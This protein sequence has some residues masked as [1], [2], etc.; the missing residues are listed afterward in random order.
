MAW[1]QHCLYHLADDGRAVIVLANGVL[2][3]GGRSGRIRQRIVKAGLLDAVIALPPGLFAFTSLPC[4]VLVFAKGRPSFDGKPAP[5]LMIDI[6]G[7]SDGRTAR[8]AT[9]GDELIDEVARVY[10]AWVAGEEPNTEVAAVAYFEDLVA[11]DFVIDPVRYISLPPSADDVDAAVRQ[12]A[13]LLRRVE[14]L[15]RASRDAD[16]QLRKMLEARR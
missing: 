9:L 5:T 7:S 8:S 11:N 15:S 2:F 10:H 12:R 1:I 16:D 4:T 14:R 13:E 6:R 3:E